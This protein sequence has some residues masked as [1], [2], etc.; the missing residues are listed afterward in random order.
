MDLRWP[1]TVT[2]EE[3]WEPTGQKPLDRRIKKRK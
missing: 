3:F 1:E 2:N